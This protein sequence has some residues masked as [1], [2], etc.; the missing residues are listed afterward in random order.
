M[1]APASVRVLGRNYK[2]TYE[3]DAARFGY[4][5]LKIGVINVSPDQDEFSLR[6]TL[7]HECLHAVLYQQ[8][9]THAYKL[10]ESFVRPLATGIMALFQDN[11]ALV[12]T[13][14]SPVAPK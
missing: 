6:D 12:K 7:L 2:L 13:L 5:D 11:P 10:E 4:C 9:S 8:G 14:F 3:T 1:R